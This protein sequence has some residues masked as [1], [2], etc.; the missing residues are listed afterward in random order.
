[1]KFK[2]VLEDML[3]E[4]I[5]N[6]KL[7]EVMLK[8]WFGDTPTE[9]QRSEGEIYFEGFEQIKTEN[10]L[11]ENAP[12]VRAFLLNF[13]KFDVKLLGDLRYYTLPQVKYIVSEFVNINLG[14][15]EDPTPEIFRGNNLPATDERIQASKDLWFGSANLIID[16]GTLR[17]YKIYTRKD[18]MSFGY[19]LKHLIDNKPYNELEYRNV[20]CITNPDEERNMYGGYRDRRT[21]YFVIDES[22]SP[23]KTKNKQEYIYYLSALQST[24]DG[25]SKLRLTPIEN[26]GSDPQVTPEEVYS[27]YPEL[28]G[29]LEKIVFKEFEDSELGKVTDILELVNEMQT[30]KYEFAKVSK[31]LKKRYIDKNKTLKTERS[32]MTMNGALK[33]SYIDLTTKQNVFER[34]SSIELINIILSNKSET[35]SLDRR[36]KMVGLSGLK[37]LINKNILNEHWHDMRVSITNPNISLFKNKKTKKYGLWNKD[38]SDWVSF[39]GITYSSIYS[40]DETLSDSFFDENGD[41]SLVEI[42]TLNGVEDDTSFYCVFPTN[43][44]HA[45]GYFMSSK[46]WI[47]LREKIDELTASVDNFDPEVDTDLKEIGE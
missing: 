20:W 32:W 26:N 29:E 30:N 1:M 16:K 12:E 18:S 17:V 7:F 9:D 39:N 4:E 41:V 42:Y 24:K 11:R 38:E 13:P 28:K 35:T 36:L 8:K 33:Q 46:S 47:K 3:S 43:T 27:I 31:S 34:F 25:G 45:N 37:Y 5:K 10:K 14:D 21:F 23:E 6:K 15:E 40:T 22:K 44:N 19:Y 2:K